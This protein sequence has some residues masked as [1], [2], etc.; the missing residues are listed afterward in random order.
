MGSATWKG[1]ALLDDETVMKRFKAS[2]GWD[3]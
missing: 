1:S 3:G 2:V